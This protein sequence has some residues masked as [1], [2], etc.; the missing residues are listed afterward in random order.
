MC[1]CNN[2]Q[3]CTNCQNNYPCNCPPTYYVAPVSNGC[4]CCPS[5][6]VKNA[7][8]GMCYP[9]VNAPTTT[10][11]VT[12]SCPCFGSTFIADAGAP[13]GAGYCED[14]NHEVTK[15][16]PV[17]TTTYITSAGKALP[18]PPVQCVP[19]EET[20]S[21]NCVT[22]VAS[23]GYPINCFGIVDGDSL[24]TMFNKLCTT[25]PGLLLTTIANTPALLTQFCQIVASCPNPPTNVSTA[26]NPGT[27][28]VTFP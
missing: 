2:P 4:L 25:L 12:W 6:Y 14:S 24:V 1:N 26:P 28:I 9:L 20:V 3:P 22:Y 16:T 19:C 18:I 17:S 21:A 8:D 23:E 7:T 27:V 13:N 15:C 10:P 11:V 5:G